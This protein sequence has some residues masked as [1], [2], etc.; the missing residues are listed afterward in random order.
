MNAIFSKNFYEQGEH[1]WLQS[2]HAI[3]ERLGDEY[4]VEPIDHEAAKSVGFRE[5]HAAGRSVV[6]HD[7]AAMVPGPADFAFPKCG[8]EGVVGVVGQ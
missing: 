5:N 3:C 6:A 1:H 7:G 2:F 8:I 4:V